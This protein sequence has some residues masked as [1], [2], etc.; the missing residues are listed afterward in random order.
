MAVQH[1]RRHH[2]AV[3]HQAHPPLAVLNDR[4]ARRVRLVLDR[5]MMAAEVLNCHPLHNEATLSLPM[6]DFRAFLAAA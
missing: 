5:Q 6:A 4:E 3:E 1:L 2:L